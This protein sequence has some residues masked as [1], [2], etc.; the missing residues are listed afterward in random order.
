M[1]TKCV[2]F[3]WPPKVMFLLFMI[4]R[5]SSINIEVSGGGSSQ[6]CDVFSGTFFH[7]H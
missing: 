7:V 4:S 2:R 6:K 1:Y 5:F 3:E